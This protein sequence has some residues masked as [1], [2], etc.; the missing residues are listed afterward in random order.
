MNTAL[1]KAH[2]EAIRRLT[3]EEDASR[4]DAITSACEIEQALR[5]LLRT[6]MIE[7]PKV[8]DLFEESCGPLSTLSSQIKL[9]WAIGLIDGELRKDLDYVRRIRNK[10][11]H[12]NEQRL[13]STRPVRDWLQQLSP[14]KDGRVAIKGHSRNEY[15]KVILEIKLSL[16]ALMLKKLNGEESIEQLREVCRGIISSAVDAIVPPPAANEEVD[17]MGERIEG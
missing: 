6:A 12:E 1:T 14:V 3:L 4:A 8:D 15:G 2:M 13:F 5:G 9:A 7:D 17:S 11:A 16:M 10:F